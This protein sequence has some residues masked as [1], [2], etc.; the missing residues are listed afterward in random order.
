MGGGGEAGTGQGIATPPGRGGVAVYDPDGERWAK[1]Q[2]AV[3]EDWLAVLAADSAAW[4]SALLPARGR[5]LA[6]LSAAY[7]SIDRPAERLT[8]ARLLA[9]YVADQPRC[10]PIC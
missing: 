8:A 3:V 4:T 10:W 7:R 1:V 5:L 2:G 9:D 6:P